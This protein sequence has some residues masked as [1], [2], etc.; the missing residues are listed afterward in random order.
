MN[1]SLFLSE[2][3]TTRVKPRLVAKQHWH[4]TAV[5]DVQRN[6]EKMLVFQLG[7]IFMLPSSRIR[8]KDLV[9]QTLKA[10]GMSYALFMRELFA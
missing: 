2:I 8:R 10:H 9:E 6:Y 7:G 4:P 5:L 3:Q 1:C